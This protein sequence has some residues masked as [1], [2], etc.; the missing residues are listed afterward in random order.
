MM[1]R[2]PMLRE[3]VSKGGGRR[4]E[5]KN[6]LGGC[7]PLRGPRIIRTNCDRRTQA[8]LLARRLAFDVSW[9]SSRLHEKVGRTRLQPRG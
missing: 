1:Q 3:D 9:L 2:I 8:T 5:P 7:H 6:V 4:N